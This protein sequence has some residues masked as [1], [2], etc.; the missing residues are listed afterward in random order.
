MLNIRT[1]TRRVQN[2]SVFE[3]GGNTKCLSQEESFHGNNIIFVQN[4]KTNIIKDSKLC[5]ATQQA[6]MPHVNMKP[7]CNPIYELNFKW[8]LL[9][10][11]VEICIIFLFVCLFCWNSFTVGW[12]TAFQ[13]WYVSIWNQIFYDDE[14]WKTRLNFINQELDCVT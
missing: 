14:K 13:F 12:A 10:S 6:A 7:V 1:Y 5:V 8:V 11:T 3:L 9:F 4:N 2:G